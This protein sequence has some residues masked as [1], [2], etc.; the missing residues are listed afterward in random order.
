MVPCAGQGSESNGGRK[1][2]KT[3]DAFVVFISLNR[4]DDDDDDLTDM[5]R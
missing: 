3:A 4:A 5:P 1:G 2:R